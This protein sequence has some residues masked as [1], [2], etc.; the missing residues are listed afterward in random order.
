MGQF[1]RHHPFVLVLFKPETIW[2][3]V[4]RD[5][6]PFNPDSVALLKN[7]GEFGGGAQGGC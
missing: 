7:G 2:R 6:D 4:S 1:N 5:N 3:G